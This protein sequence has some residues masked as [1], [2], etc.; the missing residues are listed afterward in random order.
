MFIDKHLKYL[1]ENSPL[2][3][4][5]TNQVTINEC[6]N[7]VL[8]LGASPVMS[9][10]PA[11]AQSL[12]LLANAT[13][14]NLGTI[15]ET[16]FKIMRGA[17]AGAQA[18]GRPIVFDPVGAGATP[19]RQH[20]AGLILA[21]MAPQIIRGNYAEIG[22]L[23][24]DDIGQKG[25]D[26]ASGPVL[27]SAALARKLA[28]KTKAVVAITGA[29]DV[30]SD[31][32]QSYAI[33]GGDPLMAR[34]TGTGCLLTAMIGAYVG[35]NPDEQLGATIAALAHLALAGERAVVNLDGS[36]LGTFR[37]RLFDHLATI[38]PED[39][40]AFQGIEKISEV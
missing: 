38:S 36:A 31:G 34:V 33:K 1:K 13:V 8:A 10:D 21:K 12:A 32:E 5:I 2:V 27:Q 14:L 39:L 6:A 35:A 3:L 9:G 24:G 20:Y 11:D 37:L 22:A 4:A 23:A 25:V 30:V 29:I 7:A 28:Q 15:N 40:A 18:N 19:T 16:Q 26:S 17:A